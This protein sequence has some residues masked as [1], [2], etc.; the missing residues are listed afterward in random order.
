MEHTCQQDQQPLNSRDRFLQG[1]EQQ[2]GGGFEAA[3]PLSLPKA[4]LISPNNPGHSVVQFDQEGGGNAACQVA[5]HGG[6]GGGGHGGGHGSLLLQQQKLSPFRHTQD[7]G[8][9]GSEYIQRM[10]N[11]QGQSRMPSH[12]ERAPGDDGDDDGYGEETAALGRSFLLQH[13]T[14]QFSFLQVDPSEFEPKI[15][16]FLTE[17][18]LA[19]FIHIHN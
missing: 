6:H 3:E 19:P 7:S 5:F 13:F 17:I 11:Q 2:R 14:L 9:Q 10:N 18:S 4:P 16:L 12:E 1:I 8:Y 15:E